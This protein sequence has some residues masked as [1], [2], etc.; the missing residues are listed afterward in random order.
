MNLKKS[1]VNK[2]LIIGISVFIPIFIILLIIVCRNVI[3]PSNQDI[4]NELKNTK[5]YSSKVEYVF[6]NSKS[7]FKESTI[8][9]YSFDKG[10]R[11]EFKNGY[12]RVKVYKGE[13]IKVEENA[14]DEYILDKNIDII[15]P[16]AFIENVLSNPQDG[17]IKEVKADWGQGVYLQ[18]DMKYSG[19]NKHLNKAE[20]YVDKNKKVPVL[21]KILDDSN[22]ER[23]IIF[24]KDFKKEK[25]LNDNLF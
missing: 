2:K 8:Q 19:K 23:I 7:Q 20:L 6:K 9:Y 15:Y 11:I 17:D 22:K 25:F 14:T 16:L 4:I 10:S 24:Y 13:E 1:L 3:I 18:V 5:C 21:L 12:N